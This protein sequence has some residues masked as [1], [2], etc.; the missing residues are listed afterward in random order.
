MVAGAQ[1]AWLHR[2]VRIAVVLRRQRSMNCLKLGVEEGIDKFKRGFQPVFFLHRSG[3]SN[4]AVRHGFCRVRFQGL[5]HESRSSETVQWMLGIS[6]RVVAPMRSDVF[7]LSIRL[8]PVVSDVNVVADFTK[9]DAFKVVP[10]E[11][12]PVVLNRQ[13][14][15]PYR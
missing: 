4:E 8:Y 9:G 2:S 1:D 6:N 15:V 7:L 11:I 10:V 3:P 13:I 14:K 12:L 5:C